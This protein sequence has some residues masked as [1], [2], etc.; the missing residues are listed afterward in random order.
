M[1]VQRWQSSCWVLTQQGEGS[2]VHLFSKGTNNILE[3]CTLMTSSSPIVPLPN[4]IKLDV[5]IEHEF[6]AGGGAQRFSPQHR[7][8]LERSVF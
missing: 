5:R 6:G 2:S 4:T 1:L 7:G 8:V 3:G